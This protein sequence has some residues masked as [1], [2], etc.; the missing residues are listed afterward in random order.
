M[1]V[2]E[3]IQFIDK[4]KDTILTINDF[5]L[6]EDDSYYYLLHVRLSKARYVKQL[7]MF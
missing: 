7:E 4:E 1:L 5:I 3:D 2:L 6:K